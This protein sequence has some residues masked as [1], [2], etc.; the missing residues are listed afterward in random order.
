VRGAARER[1]P[2]P[3]QAGPSL[4]GQAR[5]WGAQPPPWRRWAGG[6]RLGWVEVRPDGGREAIW[7]LHQSVGPACGVQLP[8]LYHTLVLLA[9]TGPSRD[10]AVARER[11]EK[12]CR[13][14]RDEATEPE[15]PGVPIWR[16]E[17]RT[18]SW[19]RLSTR[20][21]RPWESVILPED[22]QRTLGDDS[23][24]FHEEATRSRYS[25]LGITY[26]RKY[27]FSGPPGAGK[28]SAALALAG[29]FG[30]PLCILPDI[31]SDYLLAALSKAAPRAIFL[32]E[33]ADVTHE[34]LR[35][36]LNA[37]DGVS[38]PDDSM[39]VLTTNNPE[40]LEAFPAL[41]RPGRIDLHL[42]FPP[43]DASTAAHLFDRFFG[44]DSDMTFGGVSS[45]EAWRVTSMAELQHRLMVCDRRGL[46][47]RDCDAFLREARGAEPGSARS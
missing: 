3:L 13:E 25:S 42:R 47:P 6:G 17:Q 28:T 40:V 8:R 33:D 36:L 46:G 44:L 37:L 26:S 2:P 21:F 41:L 12:L 29:R 9:G 16:F 18:G 39:F 30:R 1:E 7:A 24:W 38:T 10:P 32:F 34:G 45:A 35:A 20:P 23:R 5:L 31:A 27:L 43:P 22:L 14:A 19:H 11:L 15:K 4:R